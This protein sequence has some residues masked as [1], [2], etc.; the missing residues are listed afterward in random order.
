MAN[1]QVSKTHLMYVWSSNLAGV[2]ERVKSLNRE[3]RTAKAHHVRLLCGGCA[4]EGQRSENVG[5]HREC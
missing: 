1:L 2:N 5:S 3:L 4:R